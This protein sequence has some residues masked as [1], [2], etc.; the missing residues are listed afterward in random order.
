LLFKNQDSLILSVATE[1]V[2]RA[3]SAMNIVKNRLYN[4]ME[5]QWMNY[6]LITYIEKDI[7][8]A[9]SNEEIMQRF[10]GIKTR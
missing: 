7:F 9:I 3:F 2:E 6:C 8:N 10:Q 4:R 1:I 5:D